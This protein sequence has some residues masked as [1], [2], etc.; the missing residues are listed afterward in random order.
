M[1]DSDKCTHCGV[2]IGTRYTYLCRLD[3]SM[4]INTVKISRLDFITL[5]SARPSTI[6]KQMLSSNCHLFIV[7]CYFFRTYS[8]IGILYHNFNVS[9][10]ILSNA[11]AQVVNPINDTKQNERNWEQYSGDIVY[12]FGSLCT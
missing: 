12:K 3:S 6:S 4:C 11:S 7:H 8:Q 1:C 5:Q 10:K 2:N 9:P